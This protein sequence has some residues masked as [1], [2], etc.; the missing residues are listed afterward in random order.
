M[1]IFLRLYLR[2]HVPLVRQELVVL[3]EVIVQQTPGLAPVIQLV[4]QECMVGNSR[5]RRWR[6]VEDRMRAEERKGEK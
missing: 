1:P 3:Y 5:S 2:L 4:L 6:R